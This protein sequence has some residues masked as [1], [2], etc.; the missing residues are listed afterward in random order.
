M[1]IEEQWI[2]KISLY[3]N[4]IKFIRINNKDIGKHQQNGLLKIE[5]VY[6]RGDNRGVII[7][8]NVIVVITLLYEE[9]ILGQNIQ[10]VVDVMQKKKVKRICIN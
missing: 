4:K 10:K 9:R 5:M 1:T 6:S 2:N 3:D 8:V 7:F